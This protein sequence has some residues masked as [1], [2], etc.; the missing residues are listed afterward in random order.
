MRGQ[1]IGASRHASGWQ[2]DVRATFSSRGTY[3]LWCLSVGERPD[4]YKRKEPDAQTVVAG[5]ADRSTTTVT[6]QPSRKA[7]AGDVVSIS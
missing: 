3:G 2:W 5:R 7:V 6:K 4:S 1:P